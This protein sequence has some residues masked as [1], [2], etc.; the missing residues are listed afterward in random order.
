MRRNNKLEKAIKKSIDDA[1]EQ[2]SKDLKS[3]IVKTNNILYEEAVNMYD[4]YI[5]R[6]YEYE[7]TS[8][9]RDYEGQPGTKEGSYLY[10][11]KKGAI[12]KKNGH[13]PILMVDPYLFGRNM[14]ERQ[15]DYQ[16][17]SPERVME[18]VSKGI[19]FYHDNILYTWSYLY[20]GKYFEFSGGSMLDAFNEFNNQFDDLAESLIRKEMNK[21]GYR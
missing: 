15:K 13:N 18:L 4:S 12:A 7:T 3:S 8:Y 19:R 20:K 16:Y 17:D 10:E 1:M 5:R 9:I 21:L 6:F 14:P 2:V 11:G